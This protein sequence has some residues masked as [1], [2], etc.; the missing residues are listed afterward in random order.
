M[1]AEGEAPLPLGNRRGKASYFSTGVKLTTTQDGFGEGEHPP[2]GGREELR[3]GGPE[4]NGV[5][6][7]NKF[8]KKRCV[9]IRGVR[10]RGQAEKKPSYPPPIP[11]D[12]VSRRSQGGKGRPAPRR[13]SA[14]VGSGLRRSGRR[15]RGPAGRTHFWLFHRERNLTKI[16]N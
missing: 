6:K 1:W 5:K 4:K 3:G 8:F 12:L 7:I 9:V 16:H 15:P 2:H 13:G 10:V 11:D 14:P